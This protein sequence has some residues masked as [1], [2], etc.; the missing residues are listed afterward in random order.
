M[1]PAYNSNIDLIELIVSTLE[2]YLKRMHN[3]GL[4]HRNKEDWVKIIR[5]SKLAS[6]MEWKT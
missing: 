4:D 1:A 5:K 3:Y 2:I 6:I